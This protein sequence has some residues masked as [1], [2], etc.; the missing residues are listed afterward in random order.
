MT[1][2]EFFDQHGAAIIIA[3]SASLP[4]SIASVVA[5]VASILN[6][7]TSSRNEKALTAVQVRQVT[8]S[9]ELKSDIRDMGHAVTNGMG[10]AIV[11]KA[12]DTIRPAIAREAEVA[13]DKLVRT[14]IKVA[15]DLVAEQKATWDGIERRS[16]PKDRR[17]E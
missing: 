13:N 14:A 8:N 15:S 6:A 11:A 16:G 12:M 7:R 2:M 5:S 9:A 4:P 1:F 3:V 17:Q 10:R